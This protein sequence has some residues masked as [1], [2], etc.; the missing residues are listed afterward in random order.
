MSSWENYYI[1]WK[2]P[3]KLTLAAAL[4][5]PTTLPQTAFTVNSNM[6]VWRLADHPEHTYAVLQPTSG[7]WVHGLEGLTVTLYQLKG[8]VMLFQE[9]VKDCPGLLNCT[10]GLSGGSS[11]E[12]VKTN[13]RSEI[14][15]SLFL[16]LVYYIIFT[17]T[18]CQV[19]TVVWI[20]YH[21]HILI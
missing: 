19:K 11:G 3:C 21:N 20:S 7:D 8:E 9:T 1:Q 14:Y 12:P 6:F 13:T 18:H 15:N 10:V 17:V 4:P 5:L 2:V 16:P